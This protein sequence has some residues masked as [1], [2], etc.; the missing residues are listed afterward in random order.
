[1]LDD[2]ARTGL[3]Q[4]IGRRKKLCIAVTGYRR[5]RLSDAACER[6]HAAFEALFARVQSAIL[7]ET[8]VECG[9]A[10]G[11]DLAAARAC[12]AAWTLN[13]LLAMPESDWTEYLERENSV[14][15]E[16][17]R[18]LTSE[19]HVKLTVLPAPWPNYVALAERLV[20]KG[21][22]LLA[23]WDGLPGPLGGTSYV[24]GLARTAG[25]PVFV[26]N[27]YEQTRWHQLPFL[28]GSGTSR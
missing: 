4:V 5:N 8:V 7:V 16:R 13:G 15:A 25:R 1:M 2:E 10:A 17:F 14:D 23:V 3:D 11:T 18:H 21:D 24:V 6:I 27:P 20:I 28:R 19:K 26:L 9:L 22:I 12:P